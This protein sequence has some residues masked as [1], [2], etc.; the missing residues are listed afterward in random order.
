MNT[1][2]NMTGPIQNSQAINSQHAPANK[3]PNYSY[4][5]HNSLAVQPKSCHPTPEELA[6]SIQQLNDNIHNYNQR[7]QVIAD[8]A[9]GEY[10]AKIIEKNSGKVIRQIPENE[11]PTIAHNVNNSSGLIID[12]VA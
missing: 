9:T 5:T 8:D 11:R 4:K 1:P 3:N 6:K 12:K 2:V 10:I 7:L